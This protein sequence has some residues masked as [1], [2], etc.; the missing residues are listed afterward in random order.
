MICSF[1]SKLLIRNLLYL[2]SLKHISIP[3]SL[4]GDDSSGDSCLLWRQ[5]FVYF[6][7]SSISV[8]PVGPKSKELKYIAFS[9]IRLFY[10][11]ANSQKFGPSNKRLAFFRIA[12]TKIGRDN[13]TE[14]P[15]HDNKL[16][17]DFGTISSKNPNVCT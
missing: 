14:D 9:K 12:V 2:N 4:E 8:I 17:S 15:C 6:H 11:I 10:S 16:R 3:P 5:D 7:S 1:F 13:C